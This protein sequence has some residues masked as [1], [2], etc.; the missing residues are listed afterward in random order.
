MSE[1]KFLHGEC[2]QCGGHLEFPA[3]SAGTSA[4][5]PHCNQQTELLLSTG[6]TI[7]T[8]AP[9]KSIV[10]LAL[11]CLI[12]VGGLVGAM[13]ALKRAQRMTTNH[14]APQQITTNI[15]PTLPFA[16]QEFSSSAVRIE[17][18]PGSS[19]VRAIGSIMNLST[20]RR[21]GVRIEIEMKDESGR[22]LAPT[23]DYSATIEPGAT[24]NYKA[25]ILTKG[26]VSGRVAAITEE[27]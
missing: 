24:W 15:A 1:T 25:V 23:K 17:K 13:L 6:E 7:P 4:E 18:D 8:K 26:A 19:L 3:D 16:S 12:L 21:F 9:V 5:C 22:V 11:A 2:Q 10:F 20:R 14:P 27:K